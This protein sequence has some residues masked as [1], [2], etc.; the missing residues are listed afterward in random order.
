[1]KVK[2]K[3]ANKAYT[4]TELYEAAASEMGFVVPEKLHFNC[5]KINVSKHIQDKFYERYL[6]ELKADNPHFNEHEARVQITMLLAMSR[7][8]VNAKLKANEVEIFEGF[9]C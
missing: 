7:P 2:L 6:Y 8:K 3:V 4:I 5:T 9:I 1:M